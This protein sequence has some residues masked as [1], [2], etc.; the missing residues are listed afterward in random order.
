MITKNI[1][2]TAKKLPNSHLLYYFYLSNLIKNTS[3]RVITQTTGKSHD[4]IPCDN[5]QNT[6]KILWRHQNTGKS[7]DV[8]KIYHTDAI[9]E[10]EKVP[11]NGL[12][13]LCL[14]SFFL[15]TP[16]G[17][18]PSIDPPLTLQFATHIGLTILLISKLCFCHQN[19]QGRSL[20]TY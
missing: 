5:T 19:P 17:G 20:F 6:G 15:Y 9:L 1:T 2:L 18:S 8:S 4:V 7:H 14:W 12:A 3:S 13:T 16:I 11:S 10:G